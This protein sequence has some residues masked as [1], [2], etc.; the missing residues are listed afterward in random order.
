MFIRK[1]IH[2]D[3]KNH[4][5]YHTFKLL[6]SLRTERGPRQR[7]VLN[8][9]TDFSVP[10]DHWKDLANRIEEIVTGQQPLFTYGEE[11]ERLADLYARKIVAYHGEA[12][13]RRSTPDYQRIDIDTIDCEQ[14]RS[15]GAEHVVY[16][17]MKTLGL[18]EL[19]TTLGFN[20][21]FRNAA[22][23]VI[24]ARLIAPCSEK[25][26]HEWLQTISAMDDLLDTDFGTLS[27]DRVYRVS[28]MLLRH[29]DE[30]EEHL[31]ARECSLF[32]LEEKIILYDL[33]NT[34]FE[35]TGKYND[36][37]HFG[38]SKEK[39]SDCR[40]VTLG[41]VVDAD[42]FPK[43]SDVFAGNVS[44]P[45]TLAGMI[46]ALSSPGMMH[47]LVVMDAGIATADNIVW[48]KEHG[49][50][51][52]VVSRKKQGAVP[53]EMV[54]VREDARRLI[55]AA[56]V[57][58]TDEITL[59]CHSTD[60]ESKEAGITNRFSQRFEEALGK[61]RD[62]LGKK[63]GTKRYDKVL[64][65]IGRLKERF[66]RVARRY[67]IT[68]EKD[69]TKNRA[70]AIRWERTD[71]PDHCGV[72]CLRSNRLDFTEQAMFDV[73][74]MLTDIEDTFR[75]MKSELGLRPVYHQREH[76]GD[77]HLFITVLAYHVAHAIRIRLRQQGIVHSWI[78]IRKGLSS[79]IRITT[80]MKR[81]D[82]TV[83]HIRK[84]T[85]PEPFHRQIYDALHLSHRPGKTIKT[86]I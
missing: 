5:E 1:V 64:E 78:T 66:R 71:Q 55:R 37:A 65:K 80:T 42:G 85:R 30:L 45:K 79:H 53:A 25:A 72:Y 76:R 32:S 81:E 46:S 7:M 36:K 26:T 84:S 13:T 34:F 73:F 21:P 58:N 27:Q 35:G 86:M 57:R 69:T 12:A 62:A 48:L 83:I 33:T 77:G 82:G 10:E 2:T 31:R 15:V 23:G 47:P 22:M 49:Y 61:V 14:P 28:D 60:K 50:A 51:Y 56:V 75:S 4:R 8:L 68:V 39:R 11:V 40:L 18:D 17:T 29:K 43:R 16:A 19:L 41:L 59:Y 54:T 9:G 20:T 63:H 24:A 74:A 38:I 70:T 6:E 52:L 44:E 67:E 3:T